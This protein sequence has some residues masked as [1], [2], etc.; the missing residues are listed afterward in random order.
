MLGEQS[1]P[2]DDE[3]IDIIVNPYPSATRDT[4]DD[5]DTATCPEE[6]RRLVEDLVI[7]LS[8][9][10]AVLNPQVQLLFP[11][12]VN[13]L[14]DKEIY[15]ASA[16]MLSDACRHIDVVQNS[17]MSLRVFELLDFDGE[18]YRSTASLVYSLCMENKSTTK[19]FLANYYNEDRDGNNDL[20]QSVKSQ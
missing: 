9:Y 7:I 13:L 15:D 14:R 6:R 18:H 4:L 1:T 20:I 8:D 2:E 5:I 3:N 19:Y 17:F 12:L 11:R 10:A 16:I